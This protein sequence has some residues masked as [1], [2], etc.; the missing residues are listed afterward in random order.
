MSTAS[1]A[2][3]PSALSPGGGG[4]RHAR[5]HHHPHP[6]HHHALPRPPRT[7]R[8]APRSR[9]PPPASHAYLQQQ[10][11]AAAQAHML[12]LALPRRPGAASCSGSVAAA[13]AEAQAAARARRAAAL[14][15]LPQPQSAHSQAQQSFHSPQ[16]QSSSQSSPHSSLAHTHSQSHHVDDE[17]PDVSPITLAD[18]SGDEGS[19]SAS[20]RMAL[21]ADDPDEN[22]EQAVY[23]AAGAGNGAPPFKQRK[24]GALESL[25]AAEPVRAWYCQG[26]RS[27][28]ICG[29][30]EREIYMRAGM[31]LCFCGREH[32]ARET[33]R[34]RVAWRECSTSAARLVFILQSPTRFPPPVLS[35]VGHLSDEPELCSLTK[36]PLLFPSCSLPPILSKQC[37]G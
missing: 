21:E 8:S 17:L 30:E 29:R 1:V 14:T 22:G 7:R 9:T 3:R 34:V 26:R 11:Q 37:S 35:A 2:T 33:S 13:L 20:C 6:H 10:A 18:E 25:L 5:R 12:A 16:S 23:A 19:P 36:C 27:R 4:S 32:A 15:A 31:E 24:M 28:E